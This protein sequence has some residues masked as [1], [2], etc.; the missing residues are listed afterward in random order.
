MS[1]KYAAKKEI[2]GPLMKLGNIFSFLGRM[3]NLKRLK[4]LE[5]GLFVDEVKGRVR[6][7]RGNVGFQGKTGL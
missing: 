5:E 6:G 2:F 7:K 4:I 1:T 3:K